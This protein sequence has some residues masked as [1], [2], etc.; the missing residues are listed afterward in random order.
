MNNGATVYYG[1]TLTVTY[2]AATGY[3]IKNQGSTSITVS[4]D[5]TASQIY[6]S[7][8]ARS[9]TYNVVYKSTNGTALGTT[10]VTAQYGSTVSVEPKTF[11]GYDAPA[12][13]SVKWDSTTAKTITFT[14]KPV[15]VAATQTLF[16]GKTWWSHDG[17]ARLTYGIK[18][19]YRNR[20]ATTVQVRVTWTNTIVANYY[21]GYKQ[22]GSVTVGNASTG[23]MTIATSSKFSSS[24]SS[25]RNA[26]VTSG[27]ITVNVSA[28]TTSVAVSG[29]WKSGVGTSGNFSGY[30][31]SIPAY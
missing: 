17:K 26:S 6:A 3:E 28:T 9:Y 5:V 16:T 21:Y 12:K 15:S 13:Q 8:S 24:S 2:T 18:V 29:S 31:M 30:K 7:V 1:D 27:W 19:E 14:Y 22:T 11:S 23:T 20:T 4:A 10:T 25:A